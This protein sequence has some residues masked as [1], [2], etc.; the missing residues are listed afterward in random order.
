MNY[1]YQA[2]IYCDDCGR[3]ICKHL[4]REGNAP[5]NPSDEWSYDSDDFPK[6][7]DND[8]ESDTP[9]HCAA[10]NECVNALTLPDGSKIGLLFGEL[11]RD[12]VKYVK[13]ALAE[14]EALGRPAS[15]RQV[16][17]LWRQHFQE[18]GYAV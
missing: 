7:A 13:E 6:R 8:E 14:D 10:G 4:T 1:I 15:A 11:T 16:T 17:A 5:A 18:K 3:A 12:G 2:D 9:Q